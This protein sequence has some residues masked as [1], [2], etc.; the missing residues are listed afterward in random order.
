[1]VKV[2]TI[3]EITRDVVKVTETIVVG[4]ILK[5]YVRT[6][7]PMPHTSVVIT[8]TEFEEIINHKIDNTN[9]TWYPYN[10]IQLIT[11]ETPRQDYFYSHGVLK[12]EVKELEQ[13]GIIDF[14]KI[15][16]E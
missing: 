7:K 8:S 14:I 16:Y 6:N 13:E 9:N 12:V 5:V 3:K 11:N 1:M 15:F 10:Y 2:L 4:K